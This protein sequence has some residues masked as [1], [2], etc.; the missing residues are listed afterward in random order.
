MICK[1]RTAG[2]RAAA[3]IV[4]AG[5]VGGTV[6]G[7][8][9][10]SPVRFTPT[11]GVDRYMTSAFADDDPVQ[12]AYLVTG[13]NYPDGLTA[14]AVAGAQ[15][16]N[17]YLVQKNSIPD[18]VRARLVYAKK[19][20]VVGGEGSIG[21]DVMT[22]LQ[23]NTRA[24]LSRV[25]GNDR[26]ETAAALSRVNYPLTVDTVTLP[27]SNVVVATG[28]DYPD[29]LA[30]SAAAAHA[31]SPLLLVSRDE[32]P[33]AVGAELQRLKPAAIT[34]VGGTDRVSDAVLQQLKAYTT[35][36]VERVSGAN[37]Y[38]TADAVSA[39]FFTGARNVTL[40]SGETFADA[41]A[42]G[43]RAGRYGGPLLLTAAACLTEG[44]NLEIERLQASFGESA[45]LASFGGLQRISEAAAK[46]TNCQPAGTAPKTYLDE[47]AYVEGSGRYRVDHAEMADRFYPRS[48][49]FDADP[50]NSDYG[51][52]TLGVKYSRFTAV[53]GVADGN[54]SGI[55]STVQVFGDERLLATATVKN[56]APVALDVDVRGVDRLKIVTT[57]PNASLSPASAQA[58]YV[59]F[60]DAAVS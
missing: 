52:W 7:A 19:I 57:T 6:A 20:V 47:L 33:A 27:V 5:L 22:W 43:A 18:S 41:L 26:F 60:G 42:A 34:V 23:Q 30:G 10:A 35:G 36:S 39:K 13:E 29:A 46:R 17:V 51:T 4:L 11:Y 54:T 8:A 21:A 37:R 14:G 49:A 28:W 9:A 45:R 24:Q 58:N 16:G 59:Y 31:N 38:Q 15:D 1:P 56:G 53:A 55:T 2:R 48:T 44:T 25:A 3:A 50:R 32:V 40:A 12:T